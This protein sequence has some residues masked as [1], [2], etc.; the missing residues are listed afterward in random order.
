MSK[1]DIKPGVQLTLAQIHRL[2]KRA[3]ERSATPAQPAESDPHKMKV[4]D[5]KDWLTEQGIE[6]DAAAKK[7]DLQAL[8][9]QE[10]E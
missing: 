10:D 6:F 4:T 8:I 1:D 2:R 7:E 9:P 5:L 3:A